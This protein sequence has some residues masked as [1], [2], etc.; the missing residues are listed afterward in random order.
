MR[1]FAIAVV[2]L[3][4]SSA[5]SALRRGDLVVYCSAPEDRCGATAQAFKA[6]TGVNVS[7]VRKSSSEALAQIRA[8]A[9]DPRGDIWWGGESSLHLEA[10]TGDLTE[11][12]QSPMLWQLHSWAV[13][14][15]NQSDFRSVGISAEILG[16]RLN[17]SLL[18]GRE[19]A[20][21]RCWSDLVK[22]GLKG[23]V[24][25]DEPGSSAA[26]FVILATLVQLMGEERAFEY[27]GALHR[28]VGLYAV[29]AAPPGHASAGVAPVEVALLPGNNPVAAPHKLVVPCEGTGFEI[30]SMSIIRGTKNIINAEMWYD[31]ALSGEAQ[32]IA[33][34]VRADQ[35]PSNRS[36]NI[37]PQVRNLVDS[38]LIDYDFVRYGAAI[39]RNRLLKKWLETIALQPESRR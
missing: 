2:G 13:S 36:A 6:K 28:N 8:E 30:G 11:P 29:P 23:Q 3:I 12:Y 27:L 18:A 14:F 24:Q 16:Y 39:E 22:L 17:T 26:S 19:A 33:L 35:I 25:M 7:V 1:L 5:S 15:A 38:K 10:A 34:K 31:W 9:D 20:E 37:S 32:E 4:A 21:P